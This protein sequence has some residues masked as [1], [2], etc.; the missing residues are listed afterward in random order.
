MLPAPLQ[1]MCQDA[2]I[3]AC[4]TAAIGMSTSNLVNEITYVA[5]HTTAEITAL[6]R[7]LERPC[8]PRVGQRGLTDEE[9][10]RA[11][12]RIRFEPRCPEYP[13]VLYS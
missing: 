13:S 2:K 3:M 9:T 12:F 11:L 5:A 4:A 8:G 7:S 1:R 6:T 10:E